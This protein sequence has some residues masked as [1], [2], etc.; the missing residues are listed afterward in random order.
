MV[1]EN[2]R[3][4]GAHP[5]ENLVQTV[6]PFVNDLLVA[7]ERGA[8]RPKLAQVKC[9]VVNVNLLPILAFGGNAERAPPHGVSTFPRSGLGF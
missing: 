4:P 9:L 7:G 6:E 8:A 2:A 3:E 1:P 5:Q